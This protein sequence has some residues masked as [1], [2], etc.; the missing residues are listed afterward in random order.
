[1]DGDNRRSPWSAQACLRLYE[2]PLYLLSLTS[3]EALR[4][5]QALPLTRILHLAS[6]FR[7]NGRVR[8]AS[9]ET[10]PSA[11]S[12]TQQSPGREPWGKWGS[13]P[14][15]QGM[16]VKLR[17]EPARALKARHSKAQGVSPGNGMG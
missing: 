15:L 16:R 3:I 13:E 8:Q 17:G 10:S 2:S 1:M 9:A 4:R 7:P 14:A 6:G 11:E 12:A 5:Q